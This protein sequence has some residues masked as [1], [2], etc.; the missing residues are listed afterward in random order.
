MTEIKIPIDLAKRIADKLTNSK[1]YQQ[2]VKFLPKEKIETGRWIKVDKFPERM[3]YF[4]DENTAYG[5]NVLGDWVN[6]RKDVT[7]KYSRNRYATEEEI[8][9]AL[10]ADAE[11]RA[12]NNVNYKCLHSPT[13]T[14]DI[15]FDYHYEY[16]H[17]R[18]ELWVHDC[19]SGIIGNL[20]F[21]DGVWA[22]KIATPK[23]PESLQT[24]INELGKE[25]ILK[26]LKP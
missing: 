15:S 25:E 19:G 5:F 14:R 24:A 2:L 17:R 3:K 13:L 11:R 20:I 22:E 16:S 26:L 1:E 18:N 21:K 8:K 4:V 6:E 12:Y 7:F 23:I 10:I 9:S